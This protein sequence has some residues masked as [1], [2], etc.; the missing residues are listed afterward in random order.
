MV[1]D[2]DPLIEIQSLEHR[3]NHLMLLDEAEKFDAELFKQSFGGKKSENE[4]NYVFDDDEYMEYVLLRKEDTFLPVDCMADDGG[5]YK[6]RNHPLWFLMANGYNRDYTEFIPITV[7]KFTKIIGRHDIKVSQS[8]IEKVREFIY[9]NMRLLIQL[10]NDEIDNA[11]FIE[12]MNTYQHRMAENVEREP[13]NEMAKLRAERTNLPT[14]LWVDYEWPSRTVQHGPRVKF[15]AEQ[16]VNDSRAFPCITLNG[17]FEVL[18]LPQNTFLS[19]KD[20]RRII[21]FIK[22]NY[23]LFIKLTNGEIN[24]SVFKDSIIPLP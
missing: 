13:L 11:D 4:E 24:V 12:N 23:D 5:S 22:L 2:K 9:N 19:A 15:K 20:I 17:K 8:D 3:M 1:K 21:E 14:D 10:G 7:D 16:G 6:M 18:N